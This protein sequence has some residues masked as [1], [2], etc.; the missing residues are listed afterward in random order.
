M[1]EGVIIVIGVVIVIMTILTDF[2]YAWLD[3]RVI[4][5]NTG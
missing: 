1:L 4:V 2:I 5:R 3:P